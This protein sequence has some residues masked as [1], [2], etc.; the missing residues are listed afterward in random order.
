MARGRKDYEKAVIVVES[1]GYQDLHGRILM[2]Y[3]FEDTPFKW[4]FAGDGAHFETRQ[5]RAAYN[6]SIGAELAVASDAPPAV[7]Y[8]QMFRH[9]PVDVTERMAFEMFWRPNIIARMYQLE[10]EVELFDG[11]QYHSVEVRYDLATTIWEYNNPITGWTEIEGS[12]QTFFNAAWNEFTLSVDFS[13]DHYIRM[14][15]NNIE[16]NMGEIGC[17]NFGMLV[18]AHAVVTLTARTTSG[19][20]LIVSIDDAVL[21]ELER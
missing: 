4:M 20:Q 5:Q 6:G 1:E 8:S 7:R 13:T 17:T 3:N 19:D 14:K 16:V 10:I 12:G 18:G 9:V 21:K 11:A 2:T 15:S